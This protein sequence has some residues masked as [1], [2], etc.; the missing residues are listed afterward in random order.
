MCIRPKKREPANFEVMLKDVFLLHIM[1][2][3]CINL[4]KACKCYLFKMPSAVVVIYG[5]EKSNKCHNAE[6]VPLDQSNANTGII[7]KET[8]TTRK[9]DAPDC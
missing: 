4:Y 7:I 5:C 2:I 3:S 9:Q 1:S 6:K 8:I